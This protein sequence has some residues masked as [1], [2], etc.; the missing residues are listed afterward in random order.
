[1]KTLGILGGMGPSAS[2]LLYEKIVDGTQASC[3]QEHLD[4]ILYSHASL[5]DRTTAILQGRVE[6]MTTLLSQDCKKLEQWGA[7]CLAIPCNTSHFF[8]ED[9]K[10]AVNIPII[11]MVE[12]TVSVVVK[13][14]SKKAAILA[15]EGTYRQRLYQNK[16]E[17]LGVECVELPC[18][19]QDQVTD[20]IYKEIKA[21]LSGNLSQ[22]LELEAYLLGQEVDCI[23]LACT[24]LSVFKETANLSPRLYVDALDVLTRECI[25]QCDGKLKEV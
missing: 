13:K 3:D 15:T 6:E 23:V 14:G 18:F 11:D 10:K 1:M 8:L 12:E 5:M 2:Q 21:G 22:F 19:L 25:L 24:E 17:A 7:D 16:L 20:L 9:V 4:L